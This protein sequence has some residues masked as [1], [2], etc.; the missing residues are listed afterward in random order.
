MPKDWL[1]SRVNTAAGKLKK[2]L[3]IDM[4]QTECSEK[5]R[6]FVLEAKRKARRDETCN[7]EGQRPCIG[8]GNGSHDVSKG[9][10]APPR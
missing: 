10:V 6:D 2:A 8:Y 4:M 5:L 9:K 1:F 7:G 3:R